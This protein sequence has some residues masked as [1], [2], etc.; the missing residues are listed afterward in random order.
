MSRRI[1]SIKKKKKKKIR[2][3]M[4]GREKVAHGVFML[5]ECLCLEERK[6]HME[7]LCYQ[8]A[9]AWER[10]SRTWSL[11]VKGDKKRPFRQHIYVHNVLVNT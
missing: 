7:S 1:F 2:M 4:P 9:Y 3:L 6:S 11:H 8:N 5:M 10:E